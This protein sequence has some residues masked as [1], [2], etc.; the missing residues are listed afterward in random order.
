MGL[1]VVGN[2]II[3]VRH[4]AGSPVGRCEEEGVALEPVHGRLE[5]PGRT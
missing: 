2:I 3:L 5:S 4:L 1:L